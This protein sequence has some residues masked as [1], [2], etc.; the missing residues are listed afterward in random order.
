METGTQAR[1]RLRPCLCAGR[2]LEQAPSDGKAERKKKGYSG[3]I[4]QKGLDNSGVKH[5]NDVNFIRETDDEA[6]YPD[7]G[8]LQ[9][10]RG[11]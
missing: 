2:G 5:Y 9:E 3:G 6:E 4:S 10:S 1:G 7:R 8:V 11:R